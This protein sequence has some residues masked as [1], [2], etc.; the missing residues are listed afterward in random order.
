[1][2]PATPAARLRALLAEP[3]ALVVPC[4]HDAFTA[5]VAEQA[6]FPLVDVES[7]GS[8]A[9][10]FGLSDHGIGNV[11]D[12]LGHA[13]DVALAVSVPAFAD[14]DDGGGSPLAIAR[15][16]SVATRVGISGIHLDDIESGCKG[17]P[18]HADAILDDDRALARV[19]AAID[20]RGDGDLVV[21]ARTYAAD[22]ERAWRRLEAFAALGADV[23]FPV[24]HGYDAIL[25]RAGRLPRPLY[26]V[27]RR[28]VAPP[29][30]LAAAGVKFV[31]DNDVFQI[32]AKLVCDLLVE[33]R[34]EG[35]IADAA[36]RSLS[37]EEFH[38]VMGTPEAERRAIEYGLLSPRRG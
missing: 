33:L 17:F 38:R 4:V 19:R 36:S 1:M 15:A 11:S 7:A 35:Y 2:S 30:E 13:R 14:L 26:C 24:R 21:V 32:S 31:M 25:A 22:P 29:S 34:R 23:L 18:G 9:M 20:A 5:R 10:A 3:G 6:G 12:L 27:D 16:V 37:W 8:L 28:N